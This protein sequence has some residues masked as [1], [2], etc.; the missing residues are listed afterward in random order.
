MTYRIFAGVLAGAL[1]LGAAQAENSEPLNDPK[2]SAPKDEVLVPGTRLQESA[3]RLPASVSFITADRI[4]AS[5]AETVAD[6]L[7]LEAGINVRSLYGNRAVRA[8]V[9]LRGFGVTGDQNTLIL[10]DGRRLNDVDLA[11]VNFAALP[12]HNIERIEILR[13]SGSVL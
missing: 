7:A 9:D 10:L 4:V 13:G 8:T 11:T 6:L 12:L 2:S 3:F 5:P 1:A